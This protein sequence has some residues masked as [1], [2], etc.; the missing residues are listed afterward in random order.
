MHTH[1]CLM[2]QHRYSNPTVGAAVQ[3]ASMF[4]GLA[5][6]AIGCG[7]AYSVIVLNSEAKSGLVQVRGRFEHLQQLK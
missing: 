4:Q 3:F 6:S 2:C 5:A 1:A 7:P